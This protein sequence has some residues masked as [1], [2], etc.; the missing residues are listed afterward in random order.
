MILRLFFLFIVSLFPLFSAGPITH[1][2][3]AERY[4][5]IHVIQD[6]QWVHEFLIGN[7]FPDIRYL[8]HFPR[9]LTHPNVIHLDEIQSI[10]NGFEAGMKFHAWIDLAREEFV[11][12]TGVYKSVIPLAEGHQATLLKLI[13]EEIMAD[14][15]DGRQWSFLFD[16]VQAEEREFGVSD[17]VIQSWHTI[18]QYTM[19][20]RPSWLIW[21]CSYYKEVAFGILN[22]TLYNWSYL[23]PKFADDPL[24]Q[25]H[26]RKLLEHL[27]KNLALP[28]IKTN[29]STNFS[30]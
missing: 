14:L 22:S 30:K 16:Q 20:Y 28:S 15:Y 4:C 11:E 21:S 23:L 19:E 6:E 17:D 18:L 29:N 7:L 10:V 12:E 26:V 1:L 27:E 8:G 3:L 9:E 5:E 25:N 2:Y 24:F 13:E